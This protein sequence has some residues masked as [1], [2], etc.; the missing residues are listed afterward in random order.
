MWAR[1]EEVQEQHFIGLTILP[2]PCLILAPALLK[3]G[4]KIERITPL[5]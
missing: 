4:E 2:K 3:W 1:N 5:P